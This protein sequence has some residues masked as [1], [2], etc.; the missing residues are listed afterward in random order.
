MWFVYRLVV[1]QSSQVETCD[2][3][4]WTT[5]QLMV[6]GG[7]GEQMASGQSHTRTT[8]DCPNTRQ[9]DTFS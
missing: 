2:Y 7:G 6:G 3:E 5:D 9:F 1:F 8:T 4:D